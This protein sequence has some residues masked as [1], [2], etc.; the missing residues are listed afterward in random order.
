MRSTRPTRPLTFWCWLSRQRRRA[1]P[2]GDLARDAWQDETFPRRAR[3][4]DTLD[5]YLGRVGACDGTHRSLRR[6]FG[7]YLVAQSEVA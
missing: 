4:L 6:A 1:D 3:R 5:A 7:E 2:V